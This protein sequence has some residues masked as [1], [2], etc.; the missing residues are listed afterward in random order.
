MSI[1]N[2]RTEFITLIAALL[3]MSG[4]QG[5]FGGLYA[6]R[7]GLG[8]VSKG[9]TKIVRVLPNSPAAESDL[10]IGDILLSIDTQQVESTQSFLEITSKYRDSPIPLVVQRDGKMMQVEI[11][12][13]TNIPAHEGALGL[14]ITDKK[15]DTRPV[16]LLLIASII[17]LLVAVGIWRLK[18]WA[19]Y[20]FIA[21][22][23]YQVLSLIYPILA[24]YQIVDSS[25]SRF[26]PEQ[27]LLIALFVIFGEIIW[28]ILIA[29]YMYRKRNLF[30]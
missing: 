13:R 29:A 23:V 17:S 28:E 18:K 15:H 11:T 8:I 5:T 22:S 1:K 6:L 16:Y 26:S 10:K 12:P 24:G 27:S 3:L 9:E 19:L 7:N 14:E 25:R 4:V 2:K 20:G 21:L 30:S